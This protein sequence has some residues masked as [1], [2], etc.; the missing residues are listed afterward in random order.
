MLHDLSPG[1]ERARDAARHSA[2]NA[3]A[4][5]VRLSDW[6]LG[7]IADD[8][9]KPAVLLQRVGIDLER[10]T[11]ELTENDGLTQFVAPADAVLY[12]TA[13]SEALAARGDPT[14]TT[15]FVLLAVIVSDPEFREFL[16]Q[17]GVNPDRLLEV[18]A[19]DPITTAYD[20][21]AGPEFV[22]HEPADRS[23]AARA[24]DA[25][26]NRS[27]EA[28]RV[29]DDYCRFVLDDRVLTEELKTL[30]H[31]LAEAARRIAARTLLA[32]RDTLHDV[33]TGIGTTAEYTRKTTVDVAAANLKRLQESLR[34][35]EEFGKI[36]GPEFGRAIESIRYR[37]YTLE[38]AIL[39][40]A[41]ARERL[42]QAKLYLLL[43]GSQCVASLDWTIAEA[44]A[45]GVNVVQLREKQLPDR[46]LLERAKN[47]RRWTR[48]VGVLF[49]VNDRPD[50]ARS[51]EADGVHLG[52]DDLPVAVVRRIVGPDA[53]IGVSTHTPEQ[54][55]QAVL[56]GADYL[57]VG[58]AFPSNTKS[59]DRFPGLEFIREATTLT[60]LPAF[61]LGGITPNT[62]GQAIA[63]GAR[64][65]AVSAAI[66]T[67]D[68]P[69]IVARQLAFALPSLFGKN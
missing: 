44:A 35:L 40:G 52:Q 16:A 9:G 49:I 2:T 38:R 48:K 30:R 55:R 6:F 56:D 66:A 29:L 33:G 50:I 23:D 61:V 37:T 12:S 32:S 21:N 60:T 19:P 42:A 14:L 27:R 31:E 25:N 68:E 24:I 47:V 28:L 67:V 26:L 65:V 53:L 58:P 5:A 11:R 59:F 43:T 13:R 4:D 17:F 7:L 62:I 34:S 36:I 1:V 10:L 45:G 64:R 63:A 22:V 39:I 18:L 8:E 69:Q 51:V 54:V 20:E 15:D 57:G 41:A 3:G 46:E